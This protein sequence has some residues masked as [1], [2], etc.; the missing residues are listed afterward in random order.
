MHYQARAMG[1]VIL[2][3]AGEIELAKESMQRVLAVKPDYDI[4][5]FFSVYAFRKDEDVRRITHAFED[6]RHR[7]RH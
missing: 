2:A 1:V 4:D 6:I 3:M 5:E 7:V